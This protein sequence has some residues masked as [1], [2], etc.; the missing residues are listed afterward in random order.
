[1]IL[2]YPYHI[3]LNTETF[4]L[5]VNLEQVSEFH[6][7]AKAQLMENRL[8]NKT[9]TQH[10]DRFFMKLTI[11]DKVELNNWLNQVSL[12][13]KSKLAIHH[14]NN[15]LYLAKQAVTLEKTFM[16]EELQ[17]NYK[18]LIDDLNRILTLHE[19]I[20]SH[21]LCELNM[22]MF[23]K[24][25]IIAE[26]KVKDHLPKAF[27]TAILKPYLDQF[28]RDWDSII[29]HLIDS[30]TQIEELT[31]QHLYEIKKILTEY[32]KINV[33]QSFKYF[34]YNTLF[35]YLRSNELLQ[36]GKTKPPKWEPNNK[37]ARLIYVIMCLCG[38]SNV[39]IP[40]DRVGTHNKLK[41]L[42]Y[43]N[44]NDNIMKR[45]Q[46][47]FKDNSKL[48]EKINRIPKFTSAKYIPIFK[49]LEPLG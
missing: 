18:S 39:L 2:N 1:M 37:E 42:E 41:G 13:R 11:K 36:F 33:D 43:P 21:E 32:T 7:L 46:K 8:M 19:C 35:S 14:L 45:I 23:S 31:F 3:G 49:Y 48:N 4:E 10:E 29:K 40:S 12:L 27:L 5:T 26:I 15:L 16:K 34:I 17:D 28:L 25:T 38:E 44:L 6:S 30:H 22:T 9:L 47:P 20:T 24:T